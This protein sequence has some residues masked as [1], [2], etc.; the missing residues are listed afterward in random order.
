M[1]STQGGGVGVPKITREFMS[2]ADATG[3]TEH[4]L[5]FDN[6]DTLIG[7]RAKCNSRSS[8]GKGCP[9]VNKKL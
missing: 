5:K 2:P 6:K 8:N 7:T 9:K 1:P 3:G 4:N